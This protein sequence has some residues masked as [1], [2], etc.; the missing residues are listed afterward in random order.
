MPAVVRRWHSVRSKN[1]S[2]ASA[3]N[4]A[5]ACGA[6]APSSSRVM[7]P[8][9]VET[10]A[11]QVRPSAYEGSGGCGEAPQ[12]SA[13]SSVG[14]KPGGRGEAGSPSAPDEWLEPYQTMPPA[15]TATA[16]TRMP[17]PAL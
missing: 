8:W 15:T 2:W 17:Q 13:G 1:P 5:T 9:L 10:T 3:T 11:S 12:P 16:T 7:S 14:S 4:D 6:A